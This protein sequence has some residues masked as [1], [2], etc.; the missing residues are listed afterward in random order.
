MWISLQGRRANRR[1]QES[2]CAD[3]KT[4]FTAKQRTFRAPHYRDEFCPYITIGVD[5]VHGKAERA[6]PGQQAAGGW[7]DVPGNTVALKDRSYMPVAGEHMLDAEPVQDLEFAR[8]IR[9]VDDPVRFRVGRHIVT[10]RGRNVLNTDDN[11]AAPVIVVIILE[12]L[13]LAAAAAVPPV[14]TA[15]GSRLPAARRARKASYRLQ[16]GSLP[17]AA[18]AIARR[19]CQNC[20]GA[21]NRSPRR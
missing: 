18:P 14:T 3:Q 12:A 19:S 2:E 15:I 20:R 4:L 11:S 10:T 13:R 17:A 9:L 8:A 16:P 6:A 21:G 5:R 1:S 7:R